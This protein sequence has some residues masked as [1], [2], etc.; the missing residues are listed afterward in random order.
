M[1]WVICKGAI[2]IPTIKNK[3]QVLDCFQALG[4]KLD[5]ADEARLDVLGIT[6]SPDWYTYRHLQNW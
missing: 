5:P 2:P 3:E 1:N 6:D 4:W